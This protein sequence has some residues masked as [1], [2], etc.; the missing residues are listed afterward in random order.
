M[1]C[2]TCDKKVYYCECHGNDERLEE[3][4]KSDFV[5]L[6]PIEMAKRAERKAKQKEKE[7]EGK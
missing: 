2:A 1:F 5:M 6:N 3:L 7:E 4:Q